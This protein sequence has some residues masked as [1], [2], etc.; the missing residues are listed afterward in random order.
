[1]KQYRVIITLKTKCWMVKAENKKEAK[2]KALNRL[3]KQD[4]IKMIN[5]EHTFVDEL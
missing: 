3:R 4:I 5:P 2:V 1:M